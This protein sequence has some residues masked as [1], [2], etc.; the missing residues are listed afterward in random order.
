MVSA[1][2]GTLD[3]VS[4]DDARSVFRA[5]HLEDHPLLSYG[6]LPTLVAGSLATAMAEG[7][8]TLFEDPRDDLE[9]RIAAIWTAQMD[10]RSLGV[11]DDFL[12]LGGVYE[13]MNAA[14][15]RRLAEILR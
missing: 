1:G 6:D 15:V 11:N 3:L 4:H 2:L 12:E 14:T 8:C 9:R 5:V 10:V 13:F 7:R